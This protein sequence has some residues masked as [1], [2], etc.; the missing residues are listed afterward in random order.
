MIK[1][2]KTNIKITDP[3]DLEIAE[4]LKGKKEYRSGIGVDFH[5]L[6]EGRKLF[7][8][9]I[10]IV[11]NKGLLGHSDGDVL[12]HAIAD[13]ILGAVGIGDIGVYFPQEEE[14]W[15]DVRSVMILEE[16]LRMARERGWEVE[17][18]DCVLLAEE[19]KISPYREEMAKKIGECIGIEKERVNIKATTTEGMGFLGRGEGM[20]AICNVLCRRVL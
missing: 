13:A 3:Q 18:V 12:L 10:E 16:V 7:L 20:C 4:R 2:E 11:Y 1:G 19:P 9:G 5:R 6:V 15:K 17:N 8:G 14:K